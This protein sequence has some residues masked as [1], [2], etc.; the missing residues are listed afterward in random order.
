MQGNC[1]GDASVEAAEKLLRATGA[2]P[3]P[4]LLPLAPRQCLLVSNRSVLATARPVWLDALY[5]RTHQ[6]PPDP[7]DAS[8]PRG[9][10]PFAT[11]PSNDATD[12]AGL[13]MTGCTLQGD[14]VGTTAAAHDGAS[15]HVGGKMFAEGAPAIQTRSTH[16]RLA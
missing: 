4:P 9:H 14:V 7:V 10:G 11:L 6:P 12:D 8:P 13:W 15:M 2:A 5:I 1:T 16:G 3:G